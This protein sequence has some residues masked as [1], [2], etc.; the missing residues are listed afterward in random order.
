M[1]HPDRCRISRIPTNISKNHYSTNMASIDSA[2]ADLNAQL[3][4]NIRATARKYGLVESTLRRR[5][6]GQ[7]MSRQ[8]AASEYIQRLTN[9]QE[10]ALIGQI[11]RLTDRGIPPTSR[12]VRNLAEEVLNGPVGKNWTGGFVR[13]HKERLTSL[14][15]R[16]ID[17]VRVQSEYAPIFK[18]FYDLVSLN[19]LYNSYN[20]NFFLIT[21][22][23]RE[24]PYYGR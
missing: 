15:L 10:E 17:K 21:Q 2:L 24:I 18:Q 20:T 23:L 9:S 8:D 19:W 5:W 4:P 11:N 1:P 7:T 12:I 14:Y 3:H 13:R 16:N 6:K 22:C